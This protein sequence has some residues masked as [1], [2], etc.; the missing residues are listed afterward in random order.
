MK[1]KVNNCICED[2]QNTVKLHECPTCILKSGD[3]YATSS[4]LAASVTL[5]AQ[6]GT[7][8]LLMFRRTA[9]MLT[10]HNIKWKLLLS[11]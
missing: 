3:L 2:I 10:H 1:T 9:E 8:I 7:F 5:A 6:R 4:D 11:K